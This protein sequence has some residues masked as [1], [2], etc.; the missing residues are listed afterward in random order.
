M[1]PIWLSSE[2]KYFGA[3]R[4]SRVLESSG[5]RSPFGFALRPL[6]RF[7]C[8]ALIFDAAVSIGTAC[9]FIEEKVTNFI[10]PPRTAKLTK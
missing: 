5:W 9:L 1:R 8:F 10:L 7:Y 4:H 6:Q 2:Y 3:I